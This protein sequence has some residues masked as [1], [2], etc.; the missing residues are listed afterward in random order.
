M[1][2]ILSSLWLFVFNIIRMFGQLVKNKILYL[3]CALMILPMACYGHSLSGNEETTHSGI[4]HPDIFNRV[5][6]IIKNRYVEDISY[7]EL[8]QMAVKGV[9][10]NLDPH[11]TYLS[12][13]ESEEMRSYMLKGEYEG[14]GVMVGYDE[15]GLVVVVSP[16]A[17]SGAMKAGVQRGD[18]IFMVDNKSVLG[19]NLQEVVNLIRG[20]SGT[21]VKLVLLREGTN[22]P[23]E[24]DILRSKMPHTHATCDVINNIAHITIKDFSE[25]IENDLKKHITNVRKDNKI[26]GIVLDLRNNPG[27]LLTSSV[28]V[29]DL[30][31]DQEKEIVSIRG[32]DDRVLALYKAKA[33]DISEG[34]PLVVL[35]NSGSASAS[36]IV[37]GALTR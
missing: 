1:L 36:E 26:K 17:G 21:K 31:L 34:L 33:D 29:S 2:Y 4:T 18:I 27:G 8:M 3:G 23:I 32:R 24:Y 22:T 10:S 35:I 37:A 9:L 15:R 11:S 25:Q 28:G 14:V 30:F 7:E 6:S 12:P 16:I 5:I 19:L 20:K 13:K